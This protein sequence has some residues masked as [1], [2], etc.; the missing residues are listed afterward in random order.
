[1]STKAIYDALRAKYSLP[2]WAFVREVGNSTGSNCHR[3]ADAVAMGV[4]PSR[5]YDIVGI[6]VKVSRTDWLK[7]LANPAKAEAV[8]RYCDLWWLVVSDKSIVKAGELPKTWGLMALDGDKLKVVSPATR[9]EPVQPS[10]G[11]VASLLRKAIEQNLDEK[12]RKEIAG[13]AFNEGMKSGQQIEID[14]AKRLQA[15]DLAELQTLK[16]RVKRFQEESGVDIDR[17]WDTGKIGNAVRR[18]LDGETPIELASEILGS[19]ERAT[20]I[21]RDVVRGGE[22]MVEGMN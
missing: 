22:Q 15:S 21:V 16:N 19:L 1:M 4:W 3:H 12:E 18:V 6:E 13:K 2:D 5:G 20:E 9:L 10:R 8:C 17:A 11:F 14:R 7:E